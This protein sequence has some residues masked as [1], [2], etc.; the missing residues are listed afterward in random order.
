MGHSSTPEN[1]GAFI[2][3]SIGGFIL[4]SLTPVAAAMAAPPETEGWSSE[5]IRLEEVWASQEVQLSQLQ[6]LS[7]EEEQLDSRGD[8]GWSGTLEIYGYLPTT[9]N[10]YTKIGGTEA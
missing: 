3:C 1:V 2:S 5:E 4:A 10:T 7:P 6:E 9:T 8:D